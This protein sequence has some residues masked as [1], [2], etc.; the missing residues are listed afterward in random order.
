M[1]T[2]PMIER[3]PDAPYRPP[4]AEPVTLACVPWREMA[5]PGQIAAWDELA[6][7]ASEPNPFYESWYL[8]PSLCHLAGRAEVRFLRFE[9]DGQLAGLM[10]IAYTRRY[11]GRP[12]P[13]LGNWL[14]PNAFCGVPLVKRG[15]ETAFWSAVLHW[16]DRNARSSLFL[17]LT[18]LPL[19]SPLHAALESVVEA[20]GRQAEV[21]HQEARAMLASGLSAEAYLDASLSG[22]KRK[23]LRRQANRL[24]DQGTLAFAC[25]TD[26]TGLD[27]WCAA[28]LQLERSGWKGKAGS[29]LACSPATAALFRESLAGAAQRGRLERLTLT[30]DERPIAMLA[31]FITPPGAFSFKTAFDERFARYSPGVLLQCENLAVLDR[32][33]IDWTDSCA[34]ADHPMIDHIWRERRPIGRLSIA[35]GGPLRR[36]TFRQLVRAETRS[37]R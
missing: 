30:L 29:A 3:T 11:Y 9:A 2:S 35:I 27:E 21:V 1:A 36:F 26:A 8:L 13:N 22:K 5:P 25:Q 17:H 18:D 4:A 23:E 20:E 31:T 34:A 16:A 6:C 33:D 14:H 7:T 15:A 28:F 37:R 10:P 12:V 19:G 32:P 24:A